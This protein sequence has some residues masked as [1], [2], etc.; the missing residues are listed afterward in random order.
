MLP[1][2]Q[3]PFSASADGGPFCVSGAILALDIKD[4]AFLRKARE[5]FRLADEADTKQA[6]RERDDIA[7]EAGEQ[8][9]ADVLQQRQG[10][11]AQ[12]GM[13]A[14]PARPTL[15]INKVKEPVRQILNQE[16]ASD[17]GIQ[18][19]PADDFG[20]LGVIPDDTEIEVREGL[21]RRIQREPSAADARTWAFKRAVIAGRGY[22]LVLPRFLP[23]KTWDQ[24][25]AV[26]RIYNQESVK[27]DPS[28][29][30]PDGS[31]AEYWFWGTWMLAD[32]FLAEFPYTADGE[33]NPFTS[34]NDQDFMGMTE[35]YPSWFKETDGSGEGK[36]W[37]VRVEN[38]LYVERTSKQLCVLD[39][40]STVWKD[41]LPEGVEPVQTRTVTE[42]TIQ[43]SKIGGGCCEL[44]RTVIPGELMPVI[45][46]LGDEILPYDDQ[47][48]YEGIV[49]PARDAS[50]GEN[51]TI[52][53]LVETIGL[54]PIPPLHVDPDAID[55]YES[56][57]GVANTRA[58]PF[59]PSRTYDDQGRVLKE[60]HRPP[61]DPNVLPLAQAISMFDGF[62]QNTTGGAAPDRLGI[63]QS[64]QS[65]KA[66]R[67]LQDEEQ[68]NTSNFLDNLARSLRYEAMVENGMLYPIYG[69]RPGRLVRVMTGEGESQT[70]MLT[71]PEQAQQN[72]ILQQR[73]Q[74]VAKLTKD[75]HFNVLVKI[76][77]SADNRRGQFVSMFGE[78]LAADPAQMG[79]GGDLFY[80]NLD[81]P[82]AKQLAERMRVMLAQPIQQMLAAKEQGGQFDP[83]AQ[84]KI[85]RMEQQI[86]HAEAAIKEL[87]QI[88]EGKTLEARTK[89]QIE[90]LQTERDLQLERLRAQ[91]ELEK[92]RMDNATRIHVAEIAAKSKGVIQAA[93]AEH[94]AIAL[95]HTQTH[96]AEQN[97]LDRA[98]QAN[99]AAHQAAMADG[100][101]DRAEQEA[102]R[103]RQ[104]KDAAEDRAVI[105]DELNR[106]DAQEGA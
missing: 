66:I 30:M 16:R 90:Q 79:V 103:G 64:V 61:V 15:T 46:V 9:P 34:A 26:E 70:V 47:K 29:I 106:H 82:E 41:E 44:E 19:V 40:G 71:D 1:R 50:M 63:G 67:Q 23:G 68:F 99:L 25:I 48:R 35:Q 21:I 36:T 12:N 4:S 27:G 18:L 84:A 31:D 60:P 58:L 33:K 38:Y 88:A 87:S 81:I 8:W 104:H 105:R 53:K 2:G 77:K 65:G 80:K 75:A 52:S 51:Y 85:A 37:S 96:E 86:Q 42:R 98:Q 11:V 43:Y 49:R 69:S 39:D 3:G 32:K 6:Q 91:V 95:A 83:A 22:Y 14:V 92:A 72:Q 93:E 17:L 74:K 102:A 45:Q 101:A 76:S 5:R 20:D 7:F 56:W 24:E 89:M 10:Q 55:G 13:P 59:L 28:R 54:T 94:E 62:I 78:I 57:Y 100:Q 97:A 73:A